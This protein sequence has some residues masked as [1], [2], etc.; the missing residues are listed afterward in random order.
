M[1]FIT[2]PYLLYENELDQFQ[3]TYNV[4]GVPD[5]HNETQVEYANAFQ[6]AMVQELLTLPTATQTSSGVFALACLRHC[7]TDGPAFWQAQVQQYS[8]ANLLQQWFY[9]G[10]APIQILAG[11]KGFQRCVMC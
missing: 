3:I 7:L 10:V 5:L 11:C 8:Y 6:V 2:T 9:D 4:G 1:P